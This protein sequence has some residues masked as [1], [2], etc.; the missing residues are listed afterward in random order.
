MSH[1]LHHLQLCEPCPLFP[2][3]HLSNLSR[4]ELSNN[5]QNLY[6]CWNANF[7]R[8]V[9]C[10]S[11][12]EGLLHSCQ[13]TSLHFIAF[14]LLNASRYSGVCP[15][16]LCNL[17]KPCSQS[18]NAYKSVL[19]PAVWKFIVSFIA[20]LFVCHTRIHCSAFDSIIYQ[21]DN[22]HN[23][24]IHNIFTCLTFLD[25][26]TQRYMGHSVQQK[27]KA[28]HLTKYHAIKLFPLLN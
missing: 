8:I 28:R 9:H 1:F 12:S 26:V 22:T 7:V 10:I 17:I 25:P 5:I 14:V 20:G 15:R 19:I 11:P 24:S 3:D 21:H 16:F 23:P 13:R 2:W 18:V 27:A 6:N 4:F